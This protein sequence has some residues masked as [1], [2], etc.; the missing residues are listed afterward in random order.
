MISFVFNHGRVFFTLLSRLLYRTRGPVGTFDGAR[1]LSSRLLC[2]TRMTVAD[3]LSFQR[4]VVYLGR[5]T[6]PDLAMHLDRLC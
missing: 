1:R 5:H 3:H 4:V 2:S 6:Y